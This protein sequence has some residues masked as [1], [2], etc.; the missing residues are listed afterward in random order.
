MYMKQLLMP[1]QKLWNNQGKKM[2]QNITKDQHYVPKCILKNF[3]TNKK[4]S[5]IMQFSLEKKEIE[6]KNIDKVCMKRYLYGREQ[7]IEKTYSIAEDHMAKLIDEKLI[8][9][10]MD[11]TKEQLNHIKSF[12][13]AQ[14]TRTIK[15]IEKYNEIAKSLVDCILKYENIEKNNYSLEINE[16]KKNI[17]NLKMGMI[18]ALSFVNMEI[19]LFKS[20]RFVKFLIGQDPIFEFNPFLWVKEK[21]IN[22]GIGYKG[23]TIV[24]P[25]SPDYSICLYDPKIYKKFANKGILKLNIFETKELNLA[26]II[27]TNDYIYYAKQRKHDLLRMIKNSKKFLNENKLSSK[28]EKGLIHITQNNQYNVSKLCKCFKLT[29]YAKALDINKKSSLYRE[30]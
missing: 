28:M 16:R 9:G 26:Q 24:L 18:S 2:S 7:D 3:T 10:N 4:K 15:D 1:K 22:K 6:G 20:S 27:N 11:I 17:M 8:Y 13:G 25:I 5:H 14:C 12:I 21:K 29:N 30:E 19:A 23:Y